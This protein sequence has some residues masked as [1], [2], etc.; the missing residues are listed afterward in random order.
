MGD[1]TIYIAED[2]KNI[3]NLIASFLKKEGYQVL[4]FETGDDLYDTFQIQPADLVILDVMMP[5]ASGFIICSKLRDMSTVPIIMLTAKDTD[6]DYIS[7]IALGSDA[8]FTKP[9]SPVKL[10]M[11]VKAMLRRAE[12]DAAATNIKSTTDDCLVFS[13]ITIQPEK[14][15][16][17]CDKEELK[18]THTEFCLLTFLVENKERAVS[19]E[20]LL[21]KIWGYDA[22]IETRATDDTVK[23][24]R[25]KLADMNSLMQ[26]ETVRGYGFK[27]GTKEA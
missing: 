2:E 20:E 15:M 21:L 22:A 8:Y 17:F 25:R 14:F 12:M 18:L 19:R 26:I 27:L 6:E 16:V 24:L 7:G 9:F 13:D 3:R 1:K 23:R 4:A 5:G 11:Q 10:V